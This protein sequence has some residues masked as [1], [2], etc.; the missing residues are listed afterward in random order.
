MCIPCV[1][2]HIRPPP[3]LPAAL[4]MLIRS[5]NP[6]A[7]VYARPHVFVI[8]RKWAT[9][10]AIRVPNDAYGRAVVDA[11]A[12]LG[13]A[14]EVEVTLSHSGASSTIVIFRPHATMVGKEFVCLRSGHVLR[15]GPT[16]G[17]KTTDHDDDEGVAGCM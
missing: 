2:W 17:Q 16:P 12:N 10:R 8:A 3:R 4:A 7:I 15:V 14:N 5:S 13:A 6:E 1:V 9:P 11:T